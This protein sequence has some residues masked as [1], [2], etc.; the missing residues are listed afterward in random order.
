MPLNINAAEKQ[1]VSVLDL[2]GRIVAGDE[3]DGLRGRIR[4]LLVS[5]KKRILLNMGGVTRVDSTGIGML[6]ESVI[7]TAKQGGELKL[8]NLPRLI[9]NILATHRLLQA[10]DIY[11]SEEEALGSF[12]KQTKE[13]IAEHHSNS[14]A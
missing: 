14:S 13:S 8:V 11:T 2:S 5:E 10:F 7:Y 3:C 6:V 4:D 1:G 12:K 9:G